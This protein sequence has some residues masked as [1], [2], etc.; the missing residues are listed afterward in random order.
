ML[1]CKITLPDS[2]HPVIISKNPGF[3]A[4]YI[5]LDRKNFVFWFNKCKKCFFF[6]FGCWL[7]PEKFSFCPKNNG[8]ARV[9]GLQPP[10]V[11]PLWLVRPPAPI[12]LVASYF[13]S[14]AFP[15]L[16]SLRNV[17]HSPPVVKWTC[18]HIVR[19]L[20][21]TTSTSTLVCRTIN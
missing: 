11:E 18:N 6:I 9:W 2:P 20:L 4:L 15:F 10:T 5:S 14:S 21:Q 13:L 17:S 7:L 12:A 1:T 8:F 19:Y 16:L 3:R